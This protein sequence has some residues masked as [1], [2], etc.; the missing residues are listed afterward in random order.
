M[1]ARGLSNAE[2]ATRL[3]LAEATVRTHVAR[4]LA[5]SGPRDRVQAVIGAY[6]IGPVGAGERGTA[7]QSTEQTWTEAEAWP[8]LALLCEG[9]GIS[10]RNLSLCQDLSGR[11]RPRG[12]SCSGVALL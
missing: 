4:I 12:T 2:L 8:A 11:S 9:P 3:H 1:P 7:Q 10:S 6:E 5:E